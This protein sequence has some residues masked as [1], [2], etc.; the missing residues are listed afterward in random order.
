MY[1]EPV[2]T[3]APPSEVTPPDGDSSSNGVNH[4]P[5]PPQDDVDRFANTGDASSAGGFP[6]GAEDDVQVATHRVAQRLSSDD[7]AAAGDP[8][9]PSTGEVVDS[10]VR[11][12]QAVIDSARER[13]S[14]A[15]DT[16]QDVLDPSQAIADLNSDGDRAVLG[17]TL[18]TKTIVPLPRV[19]PGT[20]LKTKNDYQIVVQQVGDS[21]TPGVADDEH[22]QYE[23]TFGKGF[24]AGV[25]NKQ[26]PVPNQVE[27]TL[28]ANLYSSDEVTMT[29]E[30][31]EEAAEAVRILQ[32][33]ALEDSIRTAGEI[34]S[35]GTGGLDP[36]ASPG[37]AVANPLAEDPN[38]GG[39]GILPDGGVPLGLPGPAD[40]VAA[41]VAPS[42]A[43]KAFLRDHITSYTSRVG[44]HEREAL[45]LSF[46]RLGIEP[47]F[48][49]NQEL[50]RTVELPRGD[51]P[52]RLTYKVA[53]AF[54]LNSKQK[55]KAATLQ[56]PGGAGKLGYT[57]QN[58]SDHA[59]VSGEMSV[60]WDL[61]RDPTASPL[62]GRPVPEVDLL[63]NGE[64]GNPDQI[65]FRGRVDVARPPY[66]DV[67]RTDLERTTLK[68]SLDNPTENAAPVFNDLLNGDW[69]GALREMGPD[70]QVSA[71]RET[72]LRDGYKQQHE[73]GFSAGGNQLEF[74]VSAILQIGND[75]VVNRDTVRADG[76][77]LADRL[78][79]QRLVV[80]PRDGLNVRAA[81]G[82]ENDKV[83]TFYH[84]TFLRGNGN[85]QTDAQGME[86]VEVQGRDVNGRDI[87]GWVAARY[88]EPHPTGAMDETGRINPDLEEQGYQ[89]HTVRPGDNLWDIAAQYDADFQ[90]L[91]ELN[92]G[93]L[94]DPSLVFAGDSV[95]L[96]G[97]G[98][99]AQPTAPTVPSDPSDTSD[100]SNPSAPSDQNPSPPVPSAPP[101]ADTVPTNPSESDSTPATP[102]PTPGDPTPDQGSPSS[103]SGTDSTPTTTP[104]EPPPQ[105]SADDGD[106]NPADPARPPTDQILRD[107]Q[108]AN[109][110]G[111]IVEWEPSGFTG[112]VAD[113]FGKGEQTVK[114]TA[115][116]AAM[117]DDLNPFQL[118][119]MGD[120]FEKAY[121]ESEQRFAIPPDMAAQRR[122]NFP[123]GEDG[124]RQY[125][126]WVNNDGQRD[127]FR[128]AYWNA[129]MTKRLGS[130][131]TE[132]FT[133]AHEGAPGNPADREA[134][135]LYNNE[136]GRRIAEANPDASEDRLAQ[137]V[138]EA[139]QN[140]EA[141]VIDQ[142]GNLAWSDQVPVW[143][144]GEA[145]DPPDAG[146]NPPPTVDAA[147]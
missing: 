28:E 116:E 103:G 32:Q 98:Q 26:T 41:Q 2:E 38:A 144:H 12:G 110:P 139:I 124:D 126:Q 77:Q 48:D 93:H 16:L 102:T 42:D 18:E 20:G 94:I 21:Q 50:I 109:D 17:V 44:A 34:T 71:Q 39:S 131:F 136:L 79:G 62:D 37:D 85:T 104:T 75:D 92:S 114:C 3:A 64:L 146:G 107:Y 35:L 59:K 142:S 47:R 145:N 89:T 60:S 29:F 138:Y 115:T 86:W 6:E 112:F 127:A 88:V 70:F 63:L 141:V 91:V 100:P 99:P 55:L 125:A 9:L 66:F 49:F 56:L 137:L 147:S 121:S 68:V 73:V 120:I 30:T 97:T 81:P 129:L 83:G 132:A 118:R 82:L 31:R 10:A 113:L 143:S 78:F 36:T 87:Q 33:L 52:G 106:A 1:T 14:G 80:V 27:N 72:I 90:E 133:T 40:I 54:D 11:T 140:G 51:D 4:T 13:I 53:G 22:V 15:V 130:E 19:P 65:A 58:I 7:S 76:N 108:V 24:L 57:P 67:K 74:K 134:M 45:A 95:Y 101:P 105:G 69:E 5:P 111:G 25:F 8:N 61:T 122:S 117:L 119:D 46:R 84:G 96:P 23:V 128:H 135:D 123:P 43:D